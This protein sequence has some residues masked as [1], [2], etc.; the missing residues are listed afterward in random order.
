MR[1]IPPRW[2]RLAAAALVGALACAAVPHEA[3]ARSSGGYSRS[4]GSSRTPSFGGGGGGYRTPSFGGGY[5]RPSTSSSRPAYRPPSSAGDSAF[6][7][8]RSGAALDAF[9]RSQQ[10]APAS[11]PYAPSYGGG[12]GGYAPNRGGYGGGGAGRGAG[13]FNNNGWAAPPPAY[14]GGRRQ[15]GVWDGLFLG[16]LLNNL[17]RPGAGDFFHN[18]QSD[19]GY[20]QWRSQLNREAQDDPALRRK[21]D[22]LDQQLARRQGEPTDPGTLPPDIPVDAALAEPERTPGLPGGGG[23]TISVVLVVL[24]GAG[25][26]VFL[27]WRRQQKAGGSVSSPTNT[28]LG[29][30]AN[31]LRHKLSGEGYRPDKFRVG[32]TVALDPTPFILAGDAIKVPQPEG[33]GSGQVSVSALGQVVSGGAKLLRLYLPDDRSL[34]QLHLDQAGEPDEC[35]LFAT[36][37]EVTPA[38]PG[39]WGAWLDPREGM[40]G[41]PDFQTKD[42]KTYSRVWV[43]GNERV[44]PRAITETI[45][46]LS[47]T[48]TVQSQA[49]LYAA[50]TGAPAPAPATEFIMVAAVQDGGRAWVEIRAGIDL[51]PVT[52]QLA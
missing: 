25:G 42:G 47:G 51:N 16:M 17:T 14:Y 20:Q 12:G 38:D 1:A 5:S 3:D 52:L 4:G 27:A 32:M 10:P 33:T 40:I 35:R 26:L 49:M 9:R 13:W 30:A 21:L 15:F 45:E 48:R 36:I 46:G 39:E 43:P 6:S 34:I 28:T 31:M 50:P 8:S 44:S 18:N 2:T 29:S 11:R 7:E 23:G 41:W 19:S 22:D 37:D 24:V